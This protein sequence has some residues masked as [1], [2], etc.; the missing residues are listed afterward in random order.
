MQKSFAVI[1][2]VFDG[3]APYLQ[4]FIDHHRSIGVDRFYFVLS[5]GQSPVC[6]E[7][8]A[9]NQIG[10]LEVQS[11]KVE[12]VWREV[13]EDYVS[14]IDA[15]EYLHPEVIRFAY[16]EEFS[17]LLMPWRMT[18]ALDDDGF[19]NS[20]KP[21]FVMPQVKTV[22]KTKSLTKMGLHKTGTRGDGE[23][24]GLD[25]GL[26]FPLNHYYL[27]GLDDLLLKEGEVIALTGATKKGRTPVSFEDNVE[28][29]SKFPSRHAKAAFVLKMLEKCPKVS[30]SY[31]LKI[32]HDM[33]ARVLG[34]AQFDLTAAKS[35]LQQS[36]ESIRE[37]FFDKTI[38]KE[39]RYLQRVLSRRPKRVRFQARVIKLLQKDYEKRVLADEKP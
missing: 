13:K 37:I 29:P 36:I 23:N 8:L 34:T 33:L 25:V 31:H 35:R 4:S 39:H 6:R 18:A 11:Q 7:I 14:V 38:K 24:L 10:F 19:V 27:R 16:E 9:A 5:P 32:D 28:T 12:L 21:F 22:V 2:R 1:T 15:D 3:E 17:S 30:D 20:E 26:Q